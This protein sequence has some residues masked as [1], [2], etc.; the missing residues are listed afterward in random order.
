MR[1]GV[2]VPAKCRT[3][4]GQ[5]WG[6]KAKTAEQNGT[7]DETQKSKKWSIPSLHSV[8]FPYCNRKGPFREYGTV[9]RHQQIRA[10]TA[11]QQRHQRRTHTHTHTA[12]ATNRHFQDKIMRSGE[13]IRHK[14]PC[15]RIASSILRLW[16]NGPKQP[17]ASQHTEIMCEK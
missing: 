9:D 2:S 13:D 11:D 5:R 4:D 6:R 15:V 17:S 7:I 10:R 3:N 12:L 8:K 1:D 16:L 14:A